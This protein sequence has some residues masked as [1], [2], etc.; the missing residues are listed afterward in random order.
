MEERKDIF[1]AGQGKVGFSI[2]KPK[3]EKKGLPRILRV[4][5]L[6]DKFEVGDNLLDKEGVKFYDDVFIAFTNFDSVKVMKKIVDELYR[7]FEEEE[8]VE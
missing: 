5:K 6:V 2:L 4:A 8:K 1:V 3:E 7:R